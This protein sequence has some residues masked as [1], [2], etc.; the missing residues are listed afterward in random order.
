V[1]KKCSKSAARVK[2]R[3]SRKVQVSDFEMMRVL[4]KGCAGNV[5]LVHHKSSTD[6]YALQAITKRHVLTHQKLQHMLTEQVVLRRMAADGSDP[7]VVKIWWSFHDKENLF[8]VM[9]R[10]TCECMPRF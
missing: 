4:G 2:E 9:V 10:I 8:L 1:R 6:L 5:L 3:V 7:F